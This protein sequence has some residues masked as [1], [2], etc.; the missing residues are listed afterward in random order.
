MSL[1]TATLMHNIWSSVFPLIPA[2]LLA[3]PVSPLLRISPRSH[4]DGQ[5]WA[6]GSVLAVCA[7]NLCHHEALL[8]GVNNCLIVWWV[9]AWKQVDISQIFSVSNIRPI[10]SGSCHG[11][12]YSDSCVQTD[13]VRPSSQQGHQKLEQLLDL[14]L[15][16]LALSLILCTS[17]LEALC[18][19]FWILA[20]LQAP[21][22]PGVPPFL[23]TLSS[24]LPLHSSLFSLLTIPPPQPP[25]L[26]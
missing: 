26:L 2:A 20:L 21:W 24:P 4:G 12:S 5:T 10:A 14:T 7:I 17:S 23:W 9:G 6:P 16:S 13:I 8:N 3:S 19:H 15:P 18:L 11:F 1:F 25:S 22:L